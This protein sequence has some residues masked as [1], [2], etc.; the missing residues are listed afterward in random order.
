MEARTARRNEVGILD[1]SIG[2]LLLIQVILIALN[3]VFASAEIAV[4]SVSE[5]RVAKLAEQ[6][7]KKARRLSRL[8]AEPAQFLATIQVAITLSGFLGSALAAENFSDRLVNWLIAQG[9]T[10]SPATLNTIAVVLITLALS[11]L[12]LIFGELVPKRLAMKKSE[13]I[14]LGV[15]GM[16]SGISIFFRPVVWLL[17]VSTNAVLRLCGVDPHENS[18]Q[19]SEEEIRMMVDAGSEN[20]AIDH[21][22]KKLIQN[23]FEFDDLSAGEVATHRTDVVLLW[24]EDSMEEWAK[25]IHESRHTRYPICEDSPDH[26]IGVLNAKDYFRLTDQSRE[27]VMA[28]AVKPAY[29]VAENTKADVLFRNMKRDRKSIAIVLDEYGGMVGIVTR[30]DLIEQ[31]VGEMSS[32]EAEAPQDAPQ[33][34]RTG[35]NQWTIQGNVALRDVEAATGVTF[36]EGE[37]DTLTGLVFNT[38]GRIPEDGRQ[39]IDLDVGPVHVH[40]SG[41]S[42]HQ[43]D[44]ATVEVLP[45]RAEDTQP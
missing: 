23:I 42:E 8:T 17:S 21:E 19:V 31:L 1:D 38:L 32:D 6:G 27:R 40:V 3:A 13:E 11:Y 12:T 33:M 15:S 7:S 26:I 37:Y 14:A 22:E 10:I 36:D 25:T 18:E 29:F 43:I 24:M 16:I 45:E 5:A 9:L 20:G 2:G 35:E 39:D 30:N 41:I 28:C 34:I 4:L 44:T